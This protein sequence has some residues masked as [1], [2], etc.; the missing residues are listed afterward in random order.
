M[1]WIIFW[2]QFE[3]A[4]HSKSSLSNADKLTYL[5][6]ALK[7]GATRQVIEGLSR[8]RDNYPK[9]IDCLQRRYNRPRLIRRAHVQAIIS[10]SPLKSG[11]GK[12]HQ[13]PGLTLYHAVSPLGKLPEMQL[14]KWLPHATMQ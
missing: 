6:H 1:N 12:E 11:N 10:A 7:D 3:A 4:I 9:A 14:T 8:A 5:R 13:L 2:E